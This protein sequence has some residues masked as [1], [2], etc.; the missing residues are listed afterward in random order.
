MADG[1]KRG[2]IHETIFPEGT[3]SVITPSGAAQ[4][5]VAKKHALA[6]EASKAPGVAAV[7]AATARTYL[8]FRGSPGGNWPCGHPI[9]PSNRRAHRLRRP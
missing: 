8:G 4:I 2:R 9:T 1:G 6:F 3:T 5:P 7:V